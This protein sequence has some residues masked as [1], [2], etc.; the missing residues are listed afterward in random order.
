MFL[1]AAASELGVASRGDAGREDWP[2]PPPFPCFPR[3]AEA[4]TVHAKESTTLRS[5]CAQLLQRSWG[6]EQRQHRG[7]WVAPLPREPTGGGHAAG[8]RATRTPVGH[9]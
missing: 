6:L 9:F 1:A 7:A 3:H 5:R 8:S 2:Q 4:D